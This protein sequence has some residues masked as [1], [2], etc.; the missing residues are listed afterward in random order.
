MSPRGSRPFPPQPCLVKPCPSRALRPARSVL[1]RPGLPGRTRGSSVSGRAAFP[2]PA[3]TLTLS[4]LRSECPLDLLGPPPLGE[5]TAAETFCAS[6]HCCNPNAKDG[7]GHS[8]CSGTLGARMT[9]SR[10]S[11]PSAGL[12]RR[13]PPRAVST[14]PSSPQPPCLPLWRLWAEAACLRSQL[15]N[16]TGQSGKGTYLSCY[17]Q[18]TKANPF[19]PITTQ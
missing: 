18:K 12:C 2:A 8:G 17:K 9:R 10:G 4:R 16:G 6:V 14:L 19:P 7:A 13:A 3:L 1:P 15:V 5:S 11:G